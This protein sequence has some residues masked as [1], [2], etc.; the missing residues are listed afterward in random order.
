MSSP[1]LDKHGYTIETCKSLCVTTV[2]NQSIILHEQIASTPAQAAARA[3]P[4]SRRPKPFPAN[5]Q[6]IHAKSAV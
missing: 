2:A 4:F 3:G 1:A 5:P 6:L